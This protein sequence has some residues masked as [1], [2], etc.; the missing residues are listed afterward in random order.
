MHFIPV[1]Y[2]HLLLDKLHARMLIFKLSLYELYR[3]LIEC[4][5]FF[6]CFLNE[7][8]TMNRQLRVGSTLQ[9]VPAV[10]WLM[11]QPQI[12]MWFQLN[13]YTCKSTANE[14]GFHWA[15]THWLYYQPSTRWHALQYAGRVKLCIHGYI[16]H[17]IIQYI[18][19]NVFK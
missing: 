11:L 13:D 14:P 6:V 5:L 17:G 3:R 15:A 19:T 9:R 16:F 18:S 7:C 4:P 12:T 2:I 1:A 8:I 10:G